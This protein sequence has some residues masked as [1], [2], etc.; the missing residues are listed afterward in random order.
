MKKNKIQFMYPAIF[1]KD[2]DENYQVIFPDLNIYT[3]GE[4]MTDAFI[5]AQNL[6]KTFFTYVLKYE[7]EFNK[8]TKVDSLIPKCK[9]N[10][11]VMI[12]TAEIEVEAE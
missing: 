2:E 11:I 9:Q 8:P 1:M 5:A 4:N 3:T 10:E 12:V 6:L 7:T